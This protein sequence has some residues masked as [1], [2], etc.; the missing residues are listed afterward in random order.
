MVPWLTAP[1]TRCDR[2]KSQ[3][4]F[5]HGERV[6]KLIQEMRLFL[7]L[8]NYL[9]PA[10]AKYFSVF[11]SNAFK[12]RGIARERIENIA[13]R[14]ACRVMTGQKKDLDLADCKGPES[15]VRR[16]IRIVIFEVFLESQ[17][18]DRLCGFAALISKF[19]YPIVEFFIQVAVNLTVQIPVYERT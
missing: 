9:G 14:A 12:H 13:Y 4:L 8:S 15:A 10:G 19:R 11:F 6:R 1:E 3:G 2:E 18:D 5:H 7:E 16:V 17:T